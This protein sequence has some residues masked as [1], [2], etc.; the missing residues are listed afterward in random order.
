MALRFIDLNPTVQ[1]DLEEMVG[2]LPS[3]IES[4]GSKEG[5]GVVVSEL[6]GRRAS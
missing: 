3:I 5:A 1:A 2:A 4:N 6:V